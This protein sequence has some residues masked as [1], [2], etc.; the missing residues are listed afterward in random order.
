MRPRSLVFDL[1]GEHFRYTGGAVKLGPLT[2]LM[3]VFGVEPATVRVVMTRLRKEGWFDSVKS[4]RE[5]SYV[6][7]DK[8]WRLLDDGRSRIFERHPDEWD[9]TW[10]QALVDEAGMDR[11][12][13]KRIEKALTWWGFGSYGG[14]V[15]LSPHD[16]EKQ[17]REMLSG[18][19]ELRLQFLRCQTAGVLSDRTLADRCWNLEEL[20]ADYQLF[21]DEFR[22]QLARYRRAV[23]GPEALVQNITLIHSYRRY[24]FRDPDLPQPLLPARWR[25]RTAHQVFTEAHDILRESAATFVA[26]VIEAG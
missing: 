21:I 8:S 10:T 14:P 5:V 2:Q 16:R 25:G 3:G 12:Q 6:L 22:P 4:G 17:L 24:P 11:E 9:R 19:D 7:N 13:R 23:S 1:Y 18:D 15:W 26:S 20:D